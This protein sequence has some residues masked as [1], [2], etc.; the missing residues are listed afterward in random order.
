M[1]ARGE[2]R[3][4]AVALALAAVL[5]GASAPVAEAVPARFW[6]VVPQNNPSPEQLQRLRRGGVDSERIPIGWGSVQPT[7]NGA[8]DWSGVDSR[9]ED[10]TAAGI[11]VLPFVSG[12]P[13]WAVREDWVPGTHHGIKAPLN[14]P[15]SGVAAAG[16]SSFLGAAVERYGPGGSFWAEHP[17]LLQRPI[18]VWQIWNEENFKY[19]VVRPN[20][21]E[22]G[23]LV[24]ISST[25]IKRVDPGAQVVLGGLF[26]RPGEAK[27]K[28]RPPQAYLAGDFLQRMYRATP[29]I[30][31]KFDGVALHPYTAKYQ[32]LTP[33]IEEFRAVL[34]RNHDGGKGLWITELGWS[35]EPPSRGDSFAKGAAGQAQQLKGAF[36]L[37]VRNQAR[38]RLKRVYW[39]SVDDYAGVCNFCGGSGLF[40]SGFAPKKSWFAY[41]K[42]AGGSPR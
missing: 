5:A 7:R 21:A 10:I 26:A 40:G 32:Y 4:W 27:L 16:W 8:Y 2:V 30:K 3:A 11:E 12:A 29:G 18:R 19:F 9:V 17:A 33:E 41:V 35:S 24:K 25:A 14:L 15:A 20:P 28:V 37:L 6:G 13:T 22:Y 23:K 1:P 31:A 34:K 42:F 36:N 38:W 39:F